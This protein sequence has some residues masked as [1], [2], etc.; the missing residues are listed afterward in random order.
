MRFNTTQIAAAVLVLLAAA[1]GVVLYAGSGTG[2][3][4]PA[5]GASDEEFLEQVRHRGIATGGALKPG[6]GV[7]PGQSA[8]PDAVPRFHVATTDIH[9]GTVTNEEPS[10]HAVTIENKG[11]LPLEIIDVTTT[12]NCTQGKMAS[13]E[14]IPPNGSAEL[15]IRIIPRLISGFTSTKTLTVTTNDPKNRA[16]ELDI[17]VNIEP[18]FMVLPEEVRFGELAP[19][20]SAQAR[21]VLRQLQDEPI[22]V[23]G[24]LPLEETNMTQY[25]VTRL[26][27][28]VWEEP[29]KAEYAIDI[30]LPPDEVQSSFVEYMLIENTTARLP[31]FRYRIA[32][33]VVPETD[34][35][36]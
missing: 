36:R 1:V 29:G 33:E 26:P 32:G 15:E 25:S 31:S 16:A 13:E 6:Q 2:G 23:T 20:A 21:V 10:M 7:V 4:A 34:A 18:E 8:D 3:S 11:R 19:G 35:A 27:E 22:E 5:E 14:P 30:I 17:S 24:A 12:C 28:D 9:L